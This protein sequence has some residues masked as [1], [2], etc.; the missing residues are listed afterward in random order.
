MV[1]DVQQTSREIAF[2]FSFFFFN[3]QHRQDCDSWRVLSVRKQFSEGYE[4]RC[5]QVLCAL[6]SCDF[7]LRH[8]FTF[9]HFGTHP[10]FESSIIYHFFE[11]DSKSESFKKI[12]ECTRN[13]MGPR[14]LV[15]FHAFNIILTLFEIFCGNFDLVWVLSEMRHFQKKSSEKME[16]SFR[17]SGTS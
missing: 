7:R 9:W 3:K 12:N 4:F 6:E 17:V 14:F 10:E 1:E 8:E 15:T 11:L 5:C 16:K 13:I 2:H